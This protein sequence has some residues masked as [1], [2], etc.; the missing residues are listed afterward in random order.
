MMLILTHPV[1]GY[2]YRRNKTL[3]TYSIWHDKMELTLGKAKKA[4]FSVLEE[5][6]LLSKDEMNNPHSVFLTPNI[7]FRICL[8]PKAFI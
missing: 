7:K 1:E 2:Y 5:M 6:K 3:G 8:P 4:Y